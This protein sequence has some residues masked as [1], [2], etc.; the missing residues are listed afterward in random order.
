MHC[1]DGLGSFTGV[2]KWTC[3]FEPLDLRDVVGSS[4]SRE[5]WVIFTG[6]L[7]PLTGRRS[8]N[9]WG[10]FSYTCPFSPSSGFVSPGS[11]A[12]VMSASLSPAYKEIGLSFIMA[13]AY[14]V[15]QHTAHQTSRREWA[16][17]GRARKLVYLEGKAW[18][19]K[20]QLNHR[21]RRP[22]LLPD[23]LPV[24]GYC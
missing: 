24:G 5:Q 8:L 9:L 13:V 1:L 7:G 11:V 18:G 3:R 17:W 14:V 19:G 10:L 21:K 22:V 23:F 16:P 6:H 2:L 4:G 15:S 20:W 12:G